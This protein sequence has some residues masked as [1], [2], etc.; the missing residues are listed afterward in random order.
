M[1]ARPPRESVGS[2]RAVRSRGR[3]LHLGEQRPPHRGLLVGAVTQG[4]GARRGRR[5]KTGVWSARLGAGGCDA[6][7]SPPKALD[8]RRSPGLSDSRQDANQAGW[9]AQGGGHVGSEDAQPL[10]SPS[11]PPDRARLQRTLFSPNSVEGV[12][13]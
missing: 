3:R 9:R 8:A 13:G 1:G 2:W 4:E 11:P 12:L 6:P 10:A 5:W 7:F